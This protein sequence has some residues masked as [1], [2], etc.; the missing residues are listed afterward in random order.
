MP[1][2]RMPP[3]LVQNSNA[4]SLGAYGTLG[5]TAGTATGR[6]YQMLAVTAV[7]ITAMTVEQE[8]FAGSAALIGVAI[9]AG[10]RIPI[11]P[12]T[13]VTIT[14]TAIFFKAPNA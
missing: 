3:E 13:S 10:S 11:F 6:F 5:V 7:T 12:A 4:A 1:F 2:Y 8:N 14:G 9:P